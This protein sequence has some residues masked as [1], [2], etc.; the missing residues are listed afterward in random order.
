MKIALFLILCSGVA[1]SCLE[2]HKFNVY[3]SFYDCMSAGYQE[4]FNKNS[5]IGPEEVNEYKMYIKFICTPE[6]EIKI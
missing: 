4:S 2:P 3:D 5:Q 6:E 1:E